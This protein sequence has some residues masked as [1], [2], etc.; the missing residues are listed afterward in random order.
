MT[1][2][3]EFPGSPVR[4]RLLNAAEVFSRVLFLPLCLRLLAGAESRQVHAGP[5]L[6]VGDCV[7]QLNGKSLVRVVGRPVQRV[8]LARDRPINL[9]FAWSPLSMPIGVKKTRTL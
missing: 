7:A 1:I 2:P 8:H 6:G 9:D 4:R 3:N 5:L